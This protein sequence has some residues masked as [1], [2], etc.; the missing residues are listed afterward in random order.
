M[1]EWN[2]DS[3]H[4]ASSRVLH[5]VELGNSCRGLW[6]GAPNEQRFHPLEA[7]LLVNMAD[8]FTKMENDR[9]V[10]LVM[11]LS[12]LV[13]FPILHPRQ[14]KMPAISL[15]AGP[16][17][18]EWNTVDHHPICVLVRDQSGAFRSYSSCT[19][20]A[21]YQ[22]TL[23]PNTMCHVGWEQAPASFLR[24]LYGVE[25]VDGDRSASI[26]GAVAGGWVDVVARLLS[27]DPQRELLHAS[28]NGPLWEHALRSGSL[29]LVKFLH[30]A[31]LNVFGDP[32]CRGKRWDIL[33]GEASLTSESNKVRIFLFLVGESYPAAINYNSDNDIFCLPN[34]IADDR[35]LLMCF[36]AA[37]SNDSMKKDMEADH[38][39][40]VLSAVASGI[41]PRSLRESGN[42]FRFRS[43]AWLLNH[44]VD[45]ERSLRKVDGA[46]MLW[47]EVNQLPKFRQRY[48]GEFGDYVFRIP[49]YW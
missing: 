31:G 28:Y 10:A 19:S 16:E 47:G 17:R 18:K 27:L 5:T 2:P 39:D 4:R 3:A 6:S 7:L 32:S 33:M 9:N 21:Y 8:G 42:T 41:F 29:T 13:A 37:F 30:R 20:E 40:T 35:S 1:L 22:C 44:S 15:V 38:L 48:R 46:L 14:K 34:T 23:C 26:C 45:R 36:Q 25:V 12:N 43:F 49:R 11:T 24:A